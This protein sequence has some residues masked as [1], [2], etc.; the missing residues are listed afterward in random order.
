[1][2]YFVTETKRAAVGW[3]A[4]LALCCESANCAA[5][6]WADVAQGATACHCWVRHDVSRQGW[7]PSHRE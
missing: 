6:G 7:L 4:L 1:M 5:Q 3:L 2:T